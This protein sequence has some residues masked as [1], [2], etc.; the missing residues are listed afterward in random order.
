MLL[1]ALLTAVSLAHAP[2]P[3]MRVAAHDLDFDRRED[4]QVFVQ[5]TRAASRDYCAVHLELITPDR[6]GT[7][8]VCERGMTRLAF[9]ALPEHVRNRLTRSGQSRLFR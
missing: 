3:L 4:V 2:A 7:P 5:R 6:M 9:E 8:A 1:T